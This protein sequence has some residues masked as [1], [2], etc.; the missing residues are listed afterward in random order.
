M[1][2]VQR[3][4]ER[5]CGVLERDGSVWRGGGTEKLGE[6]LGD[7]T[8]PAD[9]DHQLICGC[10]VVDVPGVRHDPLVNMLAVCHD[11]LVNVPRVRHD[12]LV[13]VLTLRHDHW[14]D[15]KWS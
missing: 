6:A 5:A 3:G 12:P 9:N 1:R 10:S 8:L 2:R 15:L 11:P 4:G 13:D 14:R 7:L